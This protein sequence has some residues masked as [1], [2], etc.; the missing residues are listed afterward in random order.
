MVSPQTIEQTRGKVRVCLRGDDINVEFL[1]QVLGF[2][3]G[4]KP[5]QLCQECHE[6]VVSQRFRE[7][8]PPGRDMGRVVPLHKFV[9]LFS[10]FKAACATGG[11][12]SEDQKTITTGSL[13]ASPGQVRQFHVRPH[14]C[15]VIS[16]AGIV[17][18]TGLGDNMDGSQNQV[19]LVVLV[20]REGQVQ[21]ST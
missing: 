10:D 19:V 20:F 1:E 7:R 13:P 14:G 21:T 15:V 2:F 12:T 18:G 6:V 4:A 3:D 9:A 11:D 16:H 17:A 8:R 5:F